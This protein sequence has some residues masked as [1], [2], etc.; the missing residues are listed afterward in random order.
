[1]FW[2]LSSVKRQFFGGGVLACINFTYRGAL[3]VADNSVGLSRVLLDA[4]S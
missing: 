3:S 2:W 1:M 4:V